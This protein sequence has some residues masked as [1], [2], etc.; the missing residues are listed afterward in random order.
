MYTEGVLGPRKEDK[1]FRGL[2][3]TSS[4]LEKKIR[5]SRALV[6]PPDFENKTEL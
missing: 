3:W 5:T 4:G 6:E 2:H 1:D